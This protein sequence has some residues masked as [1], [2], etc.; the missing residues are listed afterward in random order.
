MP[1]SRLSVSVEVRARI[2][3]AEI[4]KAAAYTFAPP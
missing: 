2:T 4:A 1:A 3:T